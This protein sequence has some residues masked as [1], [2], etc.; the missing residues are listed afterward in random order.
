MIADWK[1]AA[2]PRR[3]L[4]AAIVLALAAP[5]STVA[6]PVTDPCNLVA[7]DAV[8]TAVGATAAAAT[9]A[10]ATPTTST[11]SYGGI[12]TIQTGSTALT[13]PARPLKRIV[14]S[15]VPHG[16]YS[17]YAGSKQTQIVFYEGTAA[18]GVY[19]VVRAFVPVQQARLVRIARLAHAKLSG[20]TE[21]PPPAPAAS[22]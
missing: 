2:R 4:P 14:V 12:L 16:F 8:A 3:A 13:N 11:C 15:S 1:R 6:A 20:S 19:V 9:S 10:A 5:V 21:T 7:A 18:A 17:T 22:P